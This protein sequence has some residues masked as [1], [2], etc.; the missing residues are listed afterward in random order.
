MKFTINSEKFK[1]IITLATHLCGSNLTLPILN[2]ILLELKEN[3]LLVSST[4]LEIG[5]LISSPVKAE[6]EGR[7]TIPGKIFSGFIS[8]LPTG[9]IKLEEKDLTINVKSK[10]FQAKILGQDPKEFPVLPKIKE[11]PLTKIEGSSFI[12]GLSKVSHVVSPSDTRV[13]ISG[14]LMKIE[15]DVLTLVGTD[16]IRL[17]EKKLTLPKEV[18]KK[19]VIVPQRTA[20]ELSYIFSNLEGKIKIALNPSQIGFAFAPQDPLDPQITLVSRLIEGQYPEYEGIIP[21]KTGTQAILDKEEFQRKIK[22][23]SLFSSRIQDVKLKFDPPK[24]LL[25]SSTSAEVGEVRSK[26]EGKLEGKPIEIV[27]NWK[28]LLDGLTA[29]D[30]SEVLFGVNEANLPAILKPIGDKSYL[31]VLMP[32]TI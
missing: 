1:K 11:E 32:K 30:S 10:G 2:N 13:E 4:N 5:L 25:I 21:K 19:S 15:K 12:K 18:E 17:G 16:S 24:P 8:S 6:K 14:I 31:Y 9:E 28:Y 27:F 29:L 22:V 20:A 7:I 3:L 23:A 26:L